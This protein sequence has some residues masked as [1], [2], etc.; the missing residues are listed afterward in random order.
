MFDLFDDVTHDDDDGKPRPIFLGSQ[1]GFTLLG[2]ETDAFGVGVASSHLAG[3]GS[4]LSALSLSPGGTSGGDK[5]QLERASGALDASSRFVGAAEVLA[6]RASQLYAQ[7]STLLPLEPRY[8]FCVVD[9][10]VRVAPTEQD[11][12]VPTVAIFPGAVAKPGSLTEALSSMRADSIVLRG[13]ASVACAKLGTTA[14]KLRKTA[15]GLAMLL[16]AAIARL[17]TGIALFE[18]GL[19]QVAVAAETASLAAHGARVEFVPQTPE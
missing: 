16:D 2:L 8:E 3:I 17:S 12:R 7:E 15:S 5:R 13:R 18:D 6:D 14:D 11:R 10:D 4:G 9:G 1:S 19:S